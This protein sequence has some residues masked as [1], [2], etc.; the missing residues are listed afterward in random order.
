[1]IK[2]FLKK[3]SLKAFS[4]EEIVLL[5]VSTIYWN[6]ENLKTL[7]VRYNGQLIFQKV[8]LFFWQIF[9]LAS[10]MGQIKKLNAIYHIG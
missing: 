6:L 4:M 7:K 1:M 5:R 8:S 9:A 2:F 10:K 3:T